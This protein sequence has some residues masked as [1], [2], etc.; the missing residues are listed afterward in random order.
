MIFENTTRW[1][2]DD[3][4][5][6]LDRALALANHDGQPIRVGIDTVVLAQHGSQ[7]EL[8]R[9]LTHPTG[10]DT[11]KL[12]LRTPERSGIDAISSLGAVAEGAV[13]LM[14]SAMREQLW[15]ACLDLVR[16]RAWSFG[17][18]NPP[19]P[20]D[21]P[22]VRVVK[23]NGKSPTAIMRQLTKAEE[24]RDSAALLLKHAQDRVNA[25]TK[26]LARAQS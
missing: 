13:G 3:L 14:P 7:V 23:Q 1:H 9:A 25:L 17:K 10:T 12:N 4:R 15:G 20:D 21:L 16:S 22:G 6:Y 8:V 24:K 5:A 2:T 26:K 11:M 19:L 18:R